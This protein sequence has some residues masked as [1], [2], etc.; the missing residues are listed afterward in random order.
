ML[1][2]TDDHV[3]CYLGIAVVINI[4]YQG[5]SEALMTIPHTV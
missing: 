2:K 3:Y 4:D 1:F 5:L